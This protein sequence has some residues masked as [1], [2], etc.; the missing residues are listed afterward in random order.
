MRVDVIDPSRQFT[1]LGIGLRHSADI[2]LDDDEQVTFIT[3]SGTEFDV[4]RKSWGYYATPS[5]NQRLPDHGLRAVLVRGNQSGKMY[6][7][8]VEVGHEQAF[9]EYVEWDGMTIVTWLDT[10]DAT[11]ALYDRMVRHAGGGEAPP[12]SGPATPIDGGPEPTV[13]RRDPSGGM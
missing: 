8:L 2:T 5:L 6:V 12:E 4:C 11:E 1:V 7:L 13:P 10:Y 9:Y 3:P